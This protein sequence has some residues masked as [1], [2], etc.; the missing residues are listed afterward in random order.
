M[1]NFDRRQTLGLLGGAA[2]MPL[3]GAPALANTKI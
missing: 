2:A 3:F 1:R